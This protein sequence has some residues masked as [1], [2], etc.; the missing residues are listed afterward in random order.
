MILVD[1]ELTKNILQTRH[2]STDNTFLVKSKKPEKA[3]G[4]FLH[5]NSILFGFPPKAGYI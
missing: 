5:S 4:D 2:L 3:Q 1:S